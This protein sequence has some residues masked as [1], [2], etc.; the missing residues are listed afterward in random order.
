MIATAAVHQP[1]IASAV[2]LSSAPEH[3]E[4]RRDAQAYLAGASPEIVRIPAARVSWAEPNPASYSQQKTR[5]FPRFQDNVSVPGVGMPENWVPRMASGGPRRRTDPIMAA[6]LTRKLHTQVDVL[7]AI[8]LTSAAKSMLPLRGIRV[9]S[10]TDPEEGWTKIVFVVDAQCTAEQA[11]AFWDYLGAEFDKW[12]ACLPHV[13][14]DE[15]CER[16]TVQ[17]SWR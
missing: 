11:L 12:R 9:G 4:R 7:T 10:F 15:L 5:L 8:T 3:V 2:D 16:F 1:T 13:E 14:A 17:V 6:R